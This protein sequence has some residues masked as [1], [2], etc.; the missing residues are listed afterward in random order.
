MSLRAKLKTKENVEEENEKLKGEIAEMRA[1]AV[2][3]EKKKAKHKAIIRDLQ[4]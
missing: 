1:R 4:G 3:E 2:E